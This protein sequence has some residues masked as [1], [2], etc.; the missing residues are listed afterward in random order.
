MLR[1]GLPAV[2][3]LNPTLREAQGALAAVLVWLAAV[4]LGH[5]APALPSIPSGVF[6]VTNYGAVADGVS[7]NTDAFQAAFDDASAHGG[8]TVVVSGP[9]TFL[10]GGSLAM[11][12]STRFQID[13][14]TTVK[15]L[16]FGQYPGL[17]GGV[18]GSQ[19]DDWLLLDRYGHDFELCGPGL[20]DGQGQLWWNANLDESVRPYEVY[21]RDASRVFVHDWN[22][23]NPPMK[24]IVMDGNNY[25][26]TVRNTTNSSP[27][28]SP[29]QNTDCLNLLGTR[30]LVQD[31]NF[32][33]CDDLIAMGRSSG[34]CI[35]ILITNVTCGTGHGISFGSLL[36]S[37]GV[38]NVTVIN[39]TFSGTENGIRFKADN[40][41][42]HGQPV[43][44]V[45]FLNIGMT[46]VLRPIIIYSYYNW[47]GSPDSVTPAIAASTNAAP[48]TSATPMWRDILLSN[49][50][51]TASSSCKQI[52]I[53]WGRTEMLV[54]NVTLQNITM[55]TP[56]GFN[57][58]N[59]R[60]VKFVDCKFTPSSVSFPTFTMYNA[61]VTV[62]NTTFPG[63]G[64]VTLD[65]MTTNIN[66][67]SN[68]FT[69]FNTQAGLTKTNV[70][71]SQPRLTI[72]SSVL[73][74]T[75]HLSLGS[76]SVLTFHLGTNA[77]TIGVRTNLTL[78]G[79]INVADGGGLAPGTYTILTNG[80]SFTWG[81]PIIGN[82]PTGAA[83][84]LDTSTPGQVKLVISST[85]PSFSLVALA[86]TNLVLNA[87]GGMANA[88]CWLLTSTNLALPL[89]NWTRVATNRFNASGGLLLTNVPASTWPAS[90]FRLQL[91]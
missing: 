43:R 70:L 5:A 37:G 72:G 48:V 87:T 74:V 55:T 79:T 67:S 10:C 19:G 15:L 75:N 47:D 52:G 44:A 14:G 59:A 60:G 26:I 58:Y 17:R 38:S 63:L 41:K 36:P 82:K 89:V 84:T 54:S 66:Q 27:D 65:G 4:G 28:M 61:E 56:A 78:A 31:C 32:R 45:R 24:H 20:L 90:F 85:P 91:P 25:D 35:D 30:C 81:N 42:A 7:T 8:G 34:A 86:G 11:H 57:V 49:V 3:R 69:L 9:G 64:P 76:S 29:S 80:G 51:G 39:C 33:G 2:W 53:I 50:W 68:T 71:S 16:P 73:L 21:L 23:T 46:N 12:S 22:S 6:Y 40:D 1:I 83:C 62:T 77:A 13:A 18:A 88:T